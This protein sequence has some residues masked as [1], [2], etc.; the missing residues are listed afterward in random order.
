[1]IL[2]YDIGTTFLK[3]AVVTETGR[4]VARAQVPVRMAESAGGSR[5]EFDADAWLSGVAL[6]TAQLGLREKDGLRA[7]V[8]SA[9][10]PTLVP[11]DADC[12][13]LAPAM[14]WM[15]RRGREEAE[16]ISE[17]TD[18]PVDPSFYLPKAFWIMRHDPELYERTRWFLPCAEY[19]DLFLT[20]NAVRILPS[21]LFAE[22]FWNETAVPRLRMDPDKLP[23]FVDMGDIIGTVT[24]GAVGDPGH[25]LGPARR[26]RRPRFHHVHPRHGEPCSRAGCATGRE[27]RRASTSAGRRPCGTRACCAS[28]TW[29]AARTMSRP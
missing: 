1:M 22:F 15:D 26:G 12:E 6:V 21:R 10:G 28:R 23:P 2:A 5:F 14:S 11:V 9:N 29:C 16:L 20:G 3:G 25:P 18:T 24:P 17:F 19:V 13:P 27:P 8:V 7:V 4:V